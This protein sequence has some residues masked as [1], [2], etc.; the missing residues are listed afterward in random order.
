MPNYAFSLPPDPP[1]TPVDFSCLNRAE[2]ETIL[3]CIKQNA[4]CHTALATAETPPSPT[5]SWTKIGLYVLAGVVT[6]MVAESQFRK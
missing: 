3:V 1:K 2:K 5:S 6:G 4:D